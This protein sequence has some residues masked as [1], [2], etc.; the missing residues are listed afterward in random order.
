MTWEDLR[1]D[2]AQQVSP[3]L[4]LAASAEAVRQ[5][6][7]EPDM[8]GR[9]PHKLAPD[10]ARYRHVIA[11]VRPDVLI[12]TGSFTGASARWFA[13][14]VPFVMT[15]DISFEAWRGKVP[16]NVVRIEGD[17]AGGPALIAVRRNLYHHPGTVMVSLDSDHSAQHVWRE[18]VTW[19]PYVSVGSYLVVEDT[20]VPLIGRVTEDPGLAVAQFLDQ[21]ANFELDEEV[22]G[23][24]P[25]GGHPGGWL[26]R[27]A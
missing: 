11:T 20:I 9:W 7:L 26:R 16:D 17:S 12:E 1:S 5:I 18:L 21:V 6:V 14:R 4:D 25:V 13:E 10:L 3:Q 19:A 23:L 27:V 8:E 15:L 2:L 24:Y 22:D